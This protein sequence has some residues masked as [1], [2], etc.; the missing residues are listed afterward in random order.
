MSKK[1]HIFKKLNSKNSVL[2]WFNKDLDYTLDINIVV[3]RFN[4][5]LNWINKEPFN[6]YPII[7]YN[8]GSNDNFKILSHHKIINVPNI[9]KCDH[10]YLYHIINNYDTLSE[11]IIFLPGSNDVHYKLSKSKNLINHIEYYKELVNIGTFTPSIKNKFRNFKLDTY[12][13]TYKNNYLLNNNTKIQK[14]ETRPFGVWYDKHFNELEINFYTW[15]GIFAISKKIIHQHPK[16]YYEKFLE[17]FKDDP[18][19]EVGHYIER[20]WFAIF[21][22]LNCKLVNYQYDM[23]KSIYL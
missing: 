15:W 11:Y 22:P 19:P 17:E 9:G 18:N 5:D 2:P 12:K 13:T 20:A 4:E 16:E 8:K 21:Y 23:N 6:R 14:S 10:T 3:S 1:Y 7:C